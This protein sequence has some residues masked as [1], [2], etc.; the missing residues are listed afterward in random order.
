MKIVFFGTPEF[1]VNTLKS[2]YVDKD[3]EIITVVTQPD[4]KV[5]RKGQLTPPPIK[6]A[7][8]KLKL[9][10]LQPINQ[11]ELY[12]SLKNIVC[13]FFV[14]I[15]YGMVLKKNILEIPKYGSINIHASLLPKYRGASPIH[16]ALLHG[17]KET[18]ISIMRMD[19][20]LD[21]GPVYLLRKTE[22]LEAD[23]IDSLSER[24]SNLSA[25]I[26]PLILKD[27]KSGFLSPIKQDHKSAT[28]CNKINKNDGEINWEKSAYEIN[29]QIRAYKNW[30]TAFTKING[31]TIKITEAEYDL[32]AKTPKNPGEFFLENGSMKISTGKGVI[33]PKKL[34]PEGKKE[35][36]V[37]DFLNGYKSLIVNPQKNPK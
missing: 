8:E 2:L 21:H 32:E 28:Y 27:I 24:L 19:V 13:D 11:K 37:N 14:V 16:E 34:Q 36:N 3:I 30:P 20:K 5:G 25:N 18:G 17:D 23:D 26:C 22:I 1:A 15:A 9:K 4:K 12:E 31:K 33:I 10:T 7:A 35:M 6:T 29:N